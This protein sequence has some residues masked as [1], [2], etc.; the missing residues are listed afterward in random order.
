MYRVNGMEDHLHIFTHVP[1][2][3]TVGTLV[4]DIKLSSSKM[5]EENSLF[6]NFDGW[7]EGYGAFTIGYSSKNHLIDYIKN[8]EAH[9]KKIDFIDE[10]KKIL[11][12]N[13]IEFD[14]KYLL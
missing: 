14:K 1:T 2:S 13:G 12:E 4:N 8:Q 5:I 3:I 10:Y 9:H 11:E 6:K 7:Q